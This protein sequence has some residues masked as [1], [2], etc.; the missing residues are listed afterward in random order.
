MPAWGKINLSQA[1][2]FTYWRKVVGRWSGRLKKTCLPMISATAS[3][4]CCRFQKEFLNRW[5]S[6]QSYNWETKYCGSTEFLP[7]MDS[8]LL[9]IRIFFFINL[10]FRKALNSDVLRDILRY[11]IMPYLVLLHRFY[12]HCKFPV[13]YQDLQIKMKQK[14]LL[15]QPGLPPSEEQA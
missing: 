6:C 1:L 2:V 8:P 14:I 11:F 15:K 10:L 9:P 12:N 4:P 13:L 3:N 7:T 5:K